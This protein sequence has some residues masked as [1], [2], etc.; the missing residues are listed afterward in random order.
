[1]KASKRDERMRF[2]LLNNNMQRKKAREWWA[3]T[4]LAWFHLSACQTWMFCCW[5]FF[6]LVLCVASIVRVAYLMH[7]DAQNGDI[8]IKYLQWAYNPY[9]ML[10]LLCWLAPLHAIWSI[11][12]FLT[13]WNFLYQKGN[14]E[15][16]R[17]RK[18]QPT[19]QP[20]WKT[21]NKSILIHQQ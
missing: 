19:N 2:T 18:N 13:L 20:E 6:H 10:W 1:M 8:Y 11:H 21:V 4:G 9:T 3:V 15:I 5:F 12:P 7:R 14:E 17:A 16:Q